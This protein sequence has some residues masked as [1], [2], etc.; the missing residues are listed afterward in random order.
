M[1]I[2]GVSAQGF[3]GV[4]DGGSTDF[5]I[6]L[7]NRRELNAWGNP[8]DD[9]KLYMAD[10]TWW[11]L[12]LIGRLAPGVSRTQAVAQLQPVF[13]TAA[14]I[15]LGGSPMKGE[16]PPVLSMVEAK[17]FPGLDMQY[18]IHCIF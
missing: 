13:Q 10:Q 18:S 9:G 15:G 16:K 12:R 17:G 11:C 1:T 7:Q 14:F 6:P 3:E 4:E 2:V 5:W 8:P